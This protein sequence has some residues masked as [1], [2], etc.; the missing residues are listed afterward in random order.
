MRSRQDYFSKMESLDENALAS[1]N[2][3]LMWA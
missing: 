2:V 1:E 3:G